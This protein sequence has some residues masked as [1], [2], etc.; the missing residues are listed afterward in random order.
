MPFFIKK[1]L[2]IAFYFQDDIIKNVNI[3][4]ISNLQKKNKTNDYE[5][6]NESWLSNDYKENFDGLFDKMDRNDLCEDVVHKLIYQLSQG[7]VLH[8]QLTDKQRLI[9]LVQVLLYLNEDKA[10]SNFGI[11]SL[12]VKYEK[13]F[14]EIK[15]GNHFNTINQK[16]IGNKEVEEQI[17]KSARTI[18]ENLLK[19][20][21][22]REK[23]ILQTKGGTSFSN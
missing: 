10:L 16:T 22:K 18:Y 5:V 14:E 4:T 23:A 21:R 11:D 2:Y 1:T 15:K 12:V 17:K 9:V 13:N 6:M 19:K 7:H 20:G 3:R 8:S